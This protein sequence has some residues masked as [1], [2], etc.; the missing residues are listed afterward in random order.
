MDYVINEGNI[1]KGLNYLKE[2]QRKI[3]QGIAD[4]LVPKKYGNPHDEYA[5]YM[6]RLNSG[7]CSQVL[8]GT[9]A[10]QYANPCG[11][12]GAYAQQTKHV[13]GRPNQM[14][15]GYYYF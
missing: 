12:G 11:G 13:F 4:L 1:N 3:G 10:S 14:N 9:K 15:P 6:K 2:N 8:P 5:A 7:S